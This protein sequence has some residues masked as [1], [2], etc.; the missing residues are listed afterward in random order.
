M[1]KS[2]RGSNVTTGSATWEL[3]DMVV[4]DVTTLIASIPSVHAG[5]DV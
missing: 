2:T 4:V 1:Q 3:V 5:A